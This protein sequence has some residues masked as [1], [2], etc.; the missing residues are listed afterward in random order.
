MIGKKESIREELQRLHALCEIIELAL[1]QALKGMAEHPA[2][3]IVRPALGGVALV[4]DHLRQACVDVHDL[5]AKRPARDLA[6]VCR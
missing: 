4:R 6:R 1:E 3:Y 5:P 2:A